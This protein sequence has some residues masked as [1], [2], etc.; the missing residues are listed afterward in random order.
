MTIV[1][2]F[3]M[4]H[5]KRR[6]AIITLNRPDALNALNLE[7]VAA[8]Q[9]CLDKWA[10]DD[11]VAAVLLCGAADKAFCAGG[12]IRGLYHGYNPKIF[13]NP[14]AKAFFSTEYALCKQIK[15]YTK[16]I[17]VWADGIVMGGGMGLAVASSHRI[18]TQTTMMAMPEI[19][20]GLFPDA[21]G[22]YFLRHMPNKIGLFLGLTGAR[23]NG[24]DALALGVADFGMAS[25]D[26]DVLIQALTTADWS[27]DA[28]KNHQMLNALL[29]QLHHN[30]TL[31][32]GW[33]LPHRDE[34]ERMMQQA[35]D[36][37]A[38]DTLARLGFNIEYIQQ[39]FK[40]YIAGSPT[41]AAITWHMANQVENMSFDEV[42]DLEY[43]V[44][45]HCSHNGEFAEGVRALLI[46]IEYIQQAF[47]TY[48]AGSPTSAA[49]TWHMANQVENM[50]F[51]EVMDLEYIVAIHCSHNGEFAEGVRAL[52]IDK[53]KNPKWQYTPDSLPDGYI[54]SHFKAW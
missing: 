23:I 50:S 30:H 40:T 11:S 26:F 45:I 32:T 4:V 24:T 39:A 25:D 34:I 27:D 28:T 13:P 9:A 41:S 38:F 1:T 37:A 29:G 43:I 53:D 2:D 47:K 20:I 15:S 49:I 33:L 8:I 36:L 51:D 3:L 31:P 46:D 10:I 44:A 52:L 7:M 42:M 6:I 19:S 18:V 17:I 14:T 12:D 5:D 16:P 22:S 54:K 21:G 35:G 48:I